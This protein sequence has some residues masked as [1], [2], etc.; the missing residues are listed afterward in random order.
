VGDPKVEERAH[1]MARVARRKEVVV[2][3][4][5]LYGAIARAVEKNFADW[6]ALPKPRHSQ[7]GALLPN[8]YPYQRAL[9][10]VRDGVA[11]NVAV[12]DLPAGV[13]QSIPRIRTGFSR[14]GHRVPCRP[15]R[16]LVSP[17]DS[18]VFPDE[19]GLPLWLEE[20]GFFNDFGPL[21]EHLRV[22]G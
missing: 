14:D 7:T 22:D 13:Q 15:A 2:G 18:M 6:D 10:A 12:G 17:D 1:L 4:G 20:S 21:P 5:D 8:P 3:T 11:V 19:S 16:A 9:D